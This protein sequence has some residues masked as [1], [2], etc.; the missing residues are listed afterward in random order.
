[1]TEGS[2]VPLQF[3]IENVE[4]LGSE[5]IVS[6][7]LAGGRVDGRKAIARLG[8]AQSL[9]VGQ[10]YDFSVPERELKY[11]DRSSEQ[12]VEARPLSWQ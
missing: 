10:T 9:E 7:L 8:S 5:W 11:F 3:R 6:G 4:Y 1:V 12:R 2:K